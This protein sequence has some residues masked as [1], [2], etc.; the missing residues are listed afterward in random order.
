[1]MVFD[2]VESYGKVFVRGK[3]IQFQEEHKF[4]EM[5]SDYFVDLS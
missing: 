1:M 3:F 4:L 2:L 5:Q